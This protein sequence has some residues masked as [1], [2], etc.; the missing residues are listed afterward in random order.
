VI[1][2][3]SA[4]VAANLPRAIHQWSKNGWKLARGAAPE[5]LKQWR[6]RMTY[7]RRVARMRKWTANRPTP[8]PRSSTRSWGFNP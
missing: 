1:D 5:N 8:Q 4:Y 6:E 3:D 7:V 2:T